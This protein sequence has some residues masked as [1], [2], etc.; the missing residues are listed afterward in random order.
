[1]R[2]V[3]T[4]QADIDSTEN[5]KN[6]VGAT[7]TDIDQWNAQIA[8]FKKEKE[9]VQQLQ[10]DQ[11]GRQQAQEEKVES[12]KLPYDFNEIFSDGDLKVTTANS[13]IIEVIKDFQRESDVLHNAEVDKLKF[14]HKEELRAASDR[15]SQLQRQNSEL[16]ATIDAGNSE[17]AQLSHE[18]TDAESKRDAAVRE[19]DAAITEIN[20]LKG[21]N[22][23][24]QQ[25]LNN[26]PAPKAAIDITPTDKLAQ[27]VKESSEAKANRGL[28]R[29]ATM[30]PEVVAPPVLPSLENNSAEVAAL[31]PE[32]P[33]VG[34]SF[35]QDEIPSG[36]GS[37][38]AGQDQGVQESQV[39]DFV[40]ASVYNTGFKI[41][42][43]H[44]NVLE[45]KVAEL[46]SV[47]AVA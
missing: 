6:E 35:R 47:K 30:L 22:Y 27:L 29:W 34:E 23:D 13:M 19:L 37:A 28:Q 17:M 39:E 44:I 2:T 43:E 46:E 41:I 9:A 14:D 8:E 7:Q 25:K 12:I 38:T 16:Q 24:L 26:A 18:K 21:W 1:M 3:E 33:N 11:E 32:L 45:A 4:I 20:Q 15:E 5:R 36:L 31:P 40:T 42:F 10:Q